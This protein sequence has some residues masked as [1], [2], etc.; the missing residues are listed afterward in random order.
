MIIFN[1]KIHAIIK[2]QQGSFIMA[3]LEIEDY[4]FTLATRVISEIHKTRNEPL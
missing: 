4:R 1:K 3:D 2:D